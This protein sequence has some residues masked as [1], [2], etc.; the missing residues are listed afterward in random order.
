MSERQSGTRDAVRDVVVYAVLRLVLVA[1]LS[2]V[3][4]G[5]GRLLGVQQ[6]PLVAAVAFA[7]VVGL[8]LGILVF[9]PQRRRASAGA[10]L[11]GQR[12]RRDRDQLHARLRGEAP[13]TEE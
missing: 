1:A 9:T 2:A 5:A 7:F 11:L 6:F 4:Y 13:P 12:R 3:I 8:P 10:E